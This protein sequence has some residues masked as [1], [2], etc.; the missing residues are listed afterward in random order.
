MATDDGTPKR[1]PDLAGYDGHL[2]IQWG[3]WADWVHR[4]D[5]EHM[6][7]FRAELK[8][9]LPD[10]PKVVDL[11]CRE[12]RIRQPWAKALSPELRAWAESL[13]QTDDE[14]VGR[15]EVVF[16]GTRRPGRPGP[17][18]EESQGMAEQDNRTRAAEAARR[19]HLNAAG[20]TF[21]LLKAEV[22]AVK[23]GWRDA[24]MLDG[25]FCG[26]LCPHVHGTVREAE[27][28]PEKESLL[29]AAT[30]RPRG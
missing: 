15:T 11:L 8:W 22:L 21:G 27:E 1:D 6:A 19:H 17:E 7:R 5:A 30:N 25:G 10:K 28:C 23:G 16:F 3:E 26:W 4:L 20:N 18:A 13:A 12:P 2:G 9:L 24:R 29:R 14:E